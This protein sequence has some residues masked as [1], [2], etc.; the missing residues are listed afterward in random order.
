[1]DPPAVSI[2]GTSGIPPCSSVAS[3]RE[4]SCYLVFQPD[5]AQQRQIQDD[6]VNL[7][8]AAIGFFAIA[9]RETPP[10]PAPSR[11]KKGSISAWLLPPKA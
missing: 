6:P 4:K 10:A 11:Y 9:K 8:A 5:I 7:I 3:M 2:D 1:M